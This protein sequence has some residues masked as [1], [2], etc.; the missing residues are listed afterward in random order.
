[1]RHRIIC[2]QTASEQSSES[3][4]VRTRNKFRVTSAAIAKRLQSKHL[5]SSK[6]GICPKTCLPWFGVQSCTCADQSKH[7]AHPNPQEGFQVCEVSF[8][9]AKS[10]IFGHIVFRYGLIRMLRWW[11]NKCAQTITV[12]MF[13][14]FL[15]ICWKKFWLSSTWKEKQKPVPFGKCLALFN[16]LLWSLYLGI[17]KNSWFHILLNYMSNWTN[18]WR[19]FTVHPVPRV[20]GEI[21]GL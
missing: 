2:A 11:L 13:M 20:F 18:D 1:M 10:Q 9:N 14:S 15:G 19:F 17:L 4:E 8:L 12:K 16:P 6:G 3:A 7:C 5:F 21:Q